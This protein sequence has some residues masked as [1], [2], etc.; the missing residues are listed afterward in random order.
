MHVAYMNRTL[1]WGGVEMKRGEAYVVEDANAAELLAR[2]ACTLDGTSTSRTSFHWKLYRRHSD[3]STMIVRPGG[4]GDLLFLTPVFR[5]LKRLY[6]HAKTTLCAFPRYLSAV[7]N[8]PN[9]DKTLTYPVLVQDMVSHYGNIAWMENCIERPGNSPIN[10]HEMHIADVF[11]SRVGIRSI[12]DKGIFYRVEPEEAEYAATAFPK[13]K[14]KRIG[15]QVFASSPVRTYPKEQQER[16]VKGLLKKGY[17]VFLF[18]GPGEIEAQHA[19]NL[20][21]LTQLPNPPTFRQSCA[22]L[23][24][25]DAVIAPDSALCHVAGALDIPTVALY[26]PFP[27]QLR[28]SAARSIHAINGHAPCA[29]C[30]HHSRHANIYPENKPCSE[31]GSCAAMAAIAPERILSRLEALL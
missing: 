30:F 2:E 13:G 1:Q 5:E 27:W 3:D 12:D 21:N 22:I 18:G 23:A 8:D 9:I 4:Y 14:R 19:P 7:S 24:T 26:G 25:C 11:A 16:L 29:P 15:V 17:S 31:I 10:P 20:I 6:P 28:T